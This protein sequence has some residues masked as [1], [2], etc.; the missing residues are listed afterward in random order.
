VSVALSVQVAV[1]ACDHVVSVALPLEVGSVIA[2]DD[3]VSVALPLEV[4]SVIACDHV[5]SVELCVQ[6]LSWP[7]RELD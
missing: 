6:T 4:R 7:T 2:C 1:I 5:V 3:V